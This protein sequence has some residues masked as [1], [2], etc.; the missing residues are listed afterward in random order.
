MAER[1]TQETSRPADPPRRLRATCAPGLSPWLRREI[2]SLGHEVEHVD[3][4]GVELRGTMR[5]SMRLILRLRTAYHV[6][7]RFADLR[8]RDGEAMYQG[9][10]RLPWERVIPTDGYVTVTSTIRNDTIRNSMFA[11]MRLKDA[12]VDRIA[13]VHGRRPDSGPTGDRT[14]VHLHWNGDDCRISLDLAGRKLSD[15]GY[16][17]IPRKAPMRETIAAAVLMECDWDGTRPL[18]VPMCGSGTLAIEAALIATGRPPGLLRSGFGIQHLLTFDED[19]W[20]DERTS[21]RKARAAA[22]PAPIIATD[23]DPEAVE[24]A[25]RNAVTAGVEQLIRFETCDFAETPLP[26]APGLAILHGEYGRRLGDPDSIRQTHRRIGD[27][28]KQR[29][30]G[31]QGAVFT[32]RE[33]SGEVGLKPTR[34]VPFENGGVDCR[35]LKYELYAGS[36]TSPKPVEAPHRNGPTE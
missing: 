31:W 22:D 33:L 2:E 25:R 7:Q 3:H 18:V 1:P 30:G 10:V 4:T 35:L 17:R 29:C 15:R 8:A 20:S 14:V 21:A 32:S 28:L 9:A 11:N 24:A 13:D 27:W 5:D 23:I 34:R 12:I 36:R 16:R 6:L 19:A 26:E